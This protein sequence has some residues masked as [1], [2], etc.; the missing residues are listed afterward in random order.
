MRVILHLE[1]RKGN[2]KE[3]PKYFELEHDTSD[4]LIVLNIEKSMNSLKGEMTYVKT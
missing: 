4:S 1:Q 2:K 3:I